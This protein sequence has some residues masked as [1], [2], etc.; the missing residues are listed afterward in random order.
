MINVGYSDSIRTFTFKNGEKENF[1]LFTIGKNS[2]IN[3][4]DVQHSEGNE[5]INIH[6]GNY[7]SFAYN[8]QLLVD[9]NHDYLSISTS[10]LLEV[11]RKLKKKG[12][13]IIGHDVWVGNEVTL[14]SGIHIG[15][16]AVIGAGTIVSKDVPPYAIVTGNPMRIVRYRFDE[17]IIDQLLRIQWWNW[18]KHK[19]DMNKEW[20]GKEIEEFVDKFETNQIKD[21]AEIEMTTNS[22][23]L[24]FIPD[25]DDTYPIWE[26]V[27]NQYLNVFSINDDITLVLR[28]EQGLN[29]DGNVNK[30]IQVISAFGVERA[31]D[32]LVVNDSISD[33]RSLFKS[34]DYFITNRNP[35]TMELVDIAN[36]FNV[37]VLSGVDTPIFDKSMYTTK[38]QQ[39]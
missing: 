22:V 17:K 16:G 35:C 38:S 39:A 6:I 9:R 24:L 8:I 5:T 29:F 34:V 3:S 10:P 33:M 31:A 27:L 18:S 32:I 2:Y 11:N 12:Q 7:C 30:V 14:L 26:K 13:I 37:T 4:M 20:F 25:F 21:I 19:I 15:H 28:I 36:L 23:R 1:P